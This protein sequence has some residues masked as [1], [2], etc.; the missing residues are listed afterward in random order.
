MFKNFRNQY[1][2]VKFNEDFSILAKIVLKF[3]NTEIMDQV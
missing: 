2:E 3:K 1:T